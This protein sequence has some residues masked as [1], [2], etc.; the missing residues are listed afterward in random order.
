M[1]EL[2]SV[3]LFFYRLGSRGLRVMGLGFRAWV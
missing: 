1:G 2:S 3:G